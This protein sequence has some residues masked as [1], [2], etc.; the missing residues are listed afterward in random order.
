MPDST[1]QGIQ[2]VP[3]RF[4]DGDDLAGNLYWGAG[5]GVKTFLVKKSRWKLV[6]ST[7]PSKDMVLERIVFKH[8]AYDAYLG[9]DAYRGREIATTGLHF[10]EALAG[11]RPDS[12]TVKRG[13]SPSRLAVG[14]KSGLVVYVG[15]DVWSLTTRS[16]SSPLSRRDT[17]ERTK[18]RPCTPK[19]DCVRTISQRRQ[20]DATFRSPASLLSP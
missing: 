20:A 3:K 6:S 9:A 16:G 1:H 4:G 7:K 12:V 15:H 17:T 13:G 10:L 19:S 18:F 2:R 5:G 14:G 11:R 8:R